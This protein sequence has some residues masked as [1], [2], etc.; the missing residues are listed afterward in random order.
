MP[1]PDLI[2]SVHAALPDVAGIWQPMQG[3]RTNRLWRVGDDVVKVFMANAASSL[4]PNDAGQE[5]AALRHF[6][7][8]GL[9]PELRAATD[10]W[11]VYRFVPGQTW[12]H[13]IGDV[14]NV[15]GQLHQSPA[16]YPPFRR[17]PTGAEALRDQTARL[18]A[19]AGLNLPLPPAPKTTEPQ[20][21]PLHGDAVA[22]NIIV[23]KAGLCLIDWQC[24]ALGDPT[25]DLATFLSPAMQTLYRGA[26]LTKSEIHTFLMAYPDQ[27]ISVRYLALRPLY[28]LRMAAHC[29]WRAQRGDH[30]FAQAA[31]AEL[32]G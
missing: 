20:V 4:F 32:D 21:C 23:G 9:A 13:A 8:L 11:I 5:A 10:D 28:R 12:H 18:M 22:G 6:A 7:P 26:P 31:Q 1:S 24:P 17:L 29:L 27:T 15:L 14:A 16:P 30:C 19:A 3:G 25:E 2:L